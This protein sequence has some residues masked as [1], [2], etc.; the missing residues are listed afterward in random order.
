MSYILGK[1]TGLNIF[2]KK[3]TIVGF[4]VLLAGCMI[5][6]VA[7]SESDAPHLHGN[8]I[9]SY[10]PYTAILFDLETGIERA[11]TRLPNGE[12]FDLTNARLTVESDGRF[13]I[14]H[15]A[16]ESIVLIAT[17]ENAT[18]YDISIHVSY[19]DTLTRKSVLDTAV[20]DAILAPLP[21][22]E[23]EPP[24]IVDDR[25]IQILE[26][27]PH[28]GYK[29]ESFNFEILIVDPAINRH[30]DIQFND[31]R[32]SGATVDGGIYDPNGELLQSFTHTTQENGYYDHTWLIPSSV[33]TRG[34]W[35]V[36]VD[37]AK[38]FDTGHTAFDSIITEFWVNERDDHTNSTIMSDDDETPLTPDPPA[39]DDP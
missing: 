27:T 16:L 2:Y 13:T 34:T 38:V 26:E 11:E 3:W 35:T 36:Q 28:M 31:G 33:T 8:L 39:P 22:Q 4:S 15:A 10:S 19:F 30:R 12:I 24:A 29:S 17:P 32:I 6:P 25:A 7:Q 9:Y 14:N 1:L 20:Y 37:V 5:L 23:P 21:H 18:N